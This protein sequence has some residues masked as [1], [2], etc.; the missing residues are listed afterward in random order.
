MHC[1]A[2]GPLI[3]TYYQAI[4]DK[5]GGDPVEAILHFT[6]IG[7]FNLLLLSLLVSPLAKFSKQALLIRTRRLLGLYAFL[8][9]FCHFARLYCI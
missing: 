7:A 2:L 1:L 6:G 8:Y 4:D 3:F 9:A 5:L